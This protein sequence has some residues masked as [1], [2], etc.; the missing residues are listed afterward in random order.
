MNGFLGN[1]AIERQSIPMQGRN[2]RW[3]RQARKPVPWRLAGGSRRFV[4][5]VVYEIYHTPELMMK[6]ARY[7]LG[8]VAV[9]TAAVAPHALAADADGDGVD[10]TQDVC[11]ATALGLPV[12][13]RGRPV[14]DLDFDCDVDLADFA[15]F[16][17]SFTGPLPPSC[18]PICALRDCGDDGCGGSCGTCGFSEFC[19]ACGLCVGECTPDCA[20]KD[21]GDD[22]CG[23]S[24]GTCAGSETCSPAGQCEPSCTPDCAGK[25]CG[26]DGC[27]GSCGTCGVT[28]TC[29]PAGACEPSCTPDCAG[30]ECGD[31]GCAGSCGTCSGSEFCTPAGQCDPI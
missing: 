19:D 13:E 16:Q 18:T 5:H 25:D 29:S 12:N 4:R 15:V 1:D 2:S 3:S 27:G 21:C 31:D 22:G 24:C 17:F 30:K 9:L 10:N 11:P 23:G 14:A 6:I 28:E 7:W 26:D 8:F 20:G